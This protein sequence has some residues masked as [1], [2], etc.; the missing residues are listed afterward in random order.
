MRPIKNIWLNICIQLILHAMF[1]IF[2]PFGS[3]EIEEPVVYVRRSRLRIC[4]KCIL[5][6]QGYKVSKTCK[7]THSQRA[8]ALDVFHLLSSSVYMMTH[9]GS[10]KL[11]LILGTFNW[12][13]CEMASDLRTI[14]AITYSDL[15]DCVWRI[16]TYLLK[17]LSIK[18]WYNL[19]RPTNHARQ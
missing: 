7:K 15:G 17:T 1:C 19:S 12:S 14:N 18:A 5:S 3:A 11:W 9:D 8:I 4:L 16:N 10:I 13:S 6:L 2:R